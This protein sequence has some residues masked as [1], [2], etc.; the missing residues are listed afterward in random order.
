M[1]NLAVVADDG[2]V[3]REHPLTMKAFEAVLQECRVTGQ[4]LSSHCDVTQ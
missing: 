3:A 4:A 1:E 2:V